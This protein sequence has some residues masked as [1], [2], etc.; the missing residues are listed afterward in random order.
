ML[1]NLALLAMEKGLFEEALTYWK[2]VQT[3][4]AG[5][6]GNRT[7]IGR[8]LVLLNRLDEA[9]AVLQEAA[10]Q[11]SASV[12]THYFLGQAYL[13]QRDYAAAVRCY[14]QAIALDPN[15]PNSH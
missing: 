12:Q 3:L 5:Y 7:N 8:M 14:H 4:D 6:P 15:A 13:H 2:K 10:Q 11:R 1:D 9:V